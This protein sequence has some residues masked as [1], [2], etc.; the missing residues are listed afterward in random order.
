MTINFWKWQIFSFYKLIFIKK[1]IEM[2][3]FS[4]G[5]FTFGFNKK[6]DEKKWHWGGFNFHPMIP[7]QKMIRGLK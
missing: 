5:F 7:N 6:I 1:N 4:F 3:F 2:C